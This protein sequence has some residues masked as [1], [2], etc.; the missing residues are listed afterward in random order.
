MIPNAT[1]VP[2]PEI[3]LALLPEVAQHFAAR[4]MIS[5]KDIK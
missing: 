4:I 3:P 1:V 5:L 2:L